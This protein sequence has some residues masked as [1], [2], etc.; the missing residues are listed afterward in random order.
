MMRRKATRLWDQAS[1]E[2]RIFENIVAHSHEMGSRGYVLPV[3][4]PIPLQ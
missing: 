2:A 4:L 3:V 1:V